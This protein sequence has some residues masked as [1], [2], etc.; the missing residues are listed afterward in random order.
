MVAHA[1]AVRVKERG[2]LKV[3]VVNSLRQPQPG[4]RFIRLGAPSTSRWVRKPH[5]HRPEPTH[6]ERL[7]VP[8]SHRPLIP[9]L[10]FQRSG[11]GVTLDLRVDWKFQR[12]ALCALGGG[13][14]G[15]ARLENVCE[16][17]THVPS[18]RIMLISKELQLACTYQEARVESNQF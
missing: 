10:P 7:G 14:V 1:D 5:Q 15:E 18:N 3:E 16:E 13:L 9:M 12:A 17:G 6:C 8:A 4:L 11:K 2:S